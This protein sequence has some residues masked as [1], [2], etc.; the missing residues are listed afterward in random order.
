MLALLV[1]S[2]VVLVVAAAMSTGCGC[3]FATHGA[4]P[5]AATGSLDSGV[6]NDSGPHYAPDAAVDAWLDAAPTDGG[7]V[8]IDDVSGK[9]S[10]K[11]VKNFSQYRGKW[12]WKIAGEFLT[13]PH[14]GETFTGRIKGK[15]RGER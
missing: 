7:T 3:D 13:G 6:L 2:T 12:N 8:R 11:V 10:V 15:L 14:A 9:G 5:D 1:R 4:P